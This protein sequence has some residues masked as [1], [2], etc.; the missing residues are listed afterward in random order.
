MPALRKTRAR[1]PR[2]DRLVLGAV[3]VLPALYVAGRRAAPPPPRAA[4]PALL[5]RLEARGLRLH[6]VPAD[7]CHG[8]V[9]RGVYLCDG[10][11]PWEQVAGLP[12]DPARACR[13]RGVVLA[14][15]FDDLMTVP[16]EDVRSWG[17]CGHRDG[18]F[19]FFGDPALLARLKAALAP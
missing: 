17:A 11:R 19:V 5:A 6:A 16:D 14:Q 10:P 4:I 12:A 2:L 3:L 1:R 9:R 8:D 7:H 15:A 13:W 18:P